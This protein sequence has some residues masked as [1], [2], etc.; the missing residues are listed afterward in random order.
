MLPSGTKR[1]TLQMLIEQ[2][3]ADGSHLYTDEYQAYN[4]LGEKYQHS[5]VQHGAKQFRKRKS[6][7]QYNRRILGTYH[8]VSVKYLQRY[9]DEVVYRWNTPLDNEGE[10]F[11]IMLSKSTGICL[12]ENSSKSK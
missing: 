1:S 7:N 11:D 3:V 5:A 4:G 10:R 6:I 9:I 2:F 8:F 12:G